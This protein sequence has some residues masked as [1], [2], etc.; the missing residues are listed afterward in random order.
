M[1]FS[2]CF[3]THS[4]SLTSPCS[5]HRCSSTFSHYISPAKT[6]VLYQL[7]SSS[8][9]NSSSSNSVEPTQRLGS[10]PW[11]SCCS[12]WSPSSHCRWSW[13]LIPGV[14]LVLLRLQVPEPLPG[15]PEQPLQNPS[16]ARQ[17][18]ECS[19]ENARI[20]RSRIRA[21]QRQPFMQ[22]FSKF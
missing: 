6:S 16:L 8:I 3:G 17:V 9:W 15:P 14:H 11:H 13:L 1:I 5:H 4:Q 18:P 12:L 22:M 19:M 7:C 21:V 2:C 20:R 10:I